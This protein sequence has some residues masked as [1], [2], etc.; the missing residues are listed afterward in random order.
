MVVDTTACSLHTSTGAAAGAAAG[1]SRFRLSDGMN[2]TCTPAHMLA[3]GLLLWSWLLRRCTRA[4]LT[5]ELHIACLYLQITGHAHS[6]ST[7]SCLRRGFG[8]S[9]SSAAAGFASAAASS[10]TLAG[11]AAL[12]AAGA[13]SAP[14]PVRSAASST[15]TA[16]AG[17]A[18]VLLLPASAVLRPPNRACSLH[19]KLGS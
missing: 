8:V 9:G 13:M 5:D 1:S 4:I 3:H 2:T 10:F 18:A 19:F 11:P 16:A 6:S 12:A 17:L 7:F 14:E 15:L